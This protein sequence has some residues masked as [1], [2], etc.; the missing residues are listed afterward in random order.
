MGP[1]IV[2]NAG[3]TAPPEG[4]GVGGGAGVLDELPITPPVIRSTIPSISPRT[5]TIV[6]PADLLAP[7]ISRRIKQNP[8]TTPP[9]MRSV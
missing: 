6:P 4:P 7:A 3:P 1:G 9:I 8:A 2:L 5:E